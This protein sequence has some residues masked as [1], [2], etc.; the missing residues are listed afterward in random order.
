MPLT[1][2][3]EGETDVPRIIFYIIVIVIVIILAYLIWRFVIVRYLGG[4]LLVPSKVSCTA[5]PSVPTGPTGYI[6]DN[7]AYLTWPAVADTDNYILYV[8]RTAS[9][10]IV[11][12]ER[13]ISVTGNSTAVVN[14]IPGTY[15]FKLSASNSCGT[16]GVS[17]ELAL[18]VTT[19]PSK[20]RMCKKDNPTICLSL[21]D[22]GSP[23]FMSQTCPNGICELNYVGEEN[24]KRDG[25]NLCLFEDNSDVIIIE[26]P[27]ITNPCTLPTK[28]NIDLGSG[29]VTTDDG[30]CLG[31]DSV[32]GSSSYNTECA[33]IFNPA[34]IRYAWTFQAT[35]F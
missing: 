8:G 35:S 28:W 10:P 3:K 4:Q 21:T 17:S 33:V 22:A 7:R 9:F 18:N 16:S 29:R 15:Y 5:A 2:R 31:A 23:G 6:K 30:L 1:V 19:W 13:T 20:F 27:T 34:D 32:N 14:L 12:A 11:L 25:V 26:D 24:L